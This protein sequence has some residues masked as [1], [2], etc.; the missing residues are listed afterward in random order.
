MNPIEKAPET[1][2]LLAL[3]DAALTVE[4][5]RAIDDAIHARV[6]GFSAALDRAIAAGALTGVIESV[7]TFRS[8]TVHFDPDR[9][10]GE[11]LA[12]QLAEIARGAGG[13]AASGE[14]WSIPFCADDEFALDLPDVAAA[15]KMEPQAVL[16]L[17]TGTVFKVYML[18]FLPGYAFMG[19]LPEALEMGRLSSPRKRVPAGSVAIAQRMC[20]AYPWESPGGWRVL[21][22]TP[23]ALFDV[24]NARRPALLAPGDSVQWRLADRAE[25]DLLLEQSRAGTFDRDRLRTVLAAAEPAA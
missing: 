22:R 4:F 6:L 23:V 14:H 16:A 3:G 13:A 11:S 17:L 9:A 1:A 15:K 8:V 10:D 24:R 18:G 7:P 5:G 25:Y 2:R 20:G 21:G 12:V 19:G